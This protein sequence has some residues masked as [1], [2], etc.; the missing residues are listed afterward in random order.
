[1]IILALIFFIILIVVHEYGHF[2]A[3]KRNGVD[4][5]EFGIGFPPKVAGKTMGKGILRSY[6]TI[7]LL[8][9]GGF[10][11]LKGE[12]DEDKVEGGFGRATFWVKTKIILAGVCM[13][14]VVAWLIFTGLALTM[15]IPSLIEDQ[16]TTGSPTTAKNYIAVGLIEPDSPADTAGLQVGD[17]LVAIG[18]Q[19]IKSD[20]GLFETT[21]TFAGQSVIIEYRRN[22]ALST[23]QTTATL[24]TVE[25]EQPFLG[26][27]PAIIEV[28]RYNVID[29]PVAGMGTLLQLSVETYKGLGRLVSDLVGGNFSEAADQVSG[30]VGV[31]VLLDNASV[32]GFEYL[33]F[34]IGVISLTLAIMNSLPIPALDG[35]RLFVTGLFRVLKKPLTKQTESAIHGT[36]FA[37]LMM[38][39]LLISVVDVQRFF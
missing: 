14:F 5:E 33:L 26:V 20:Q 30:P 12:S 17:E 38:L 10:V 8:P 13:N 37:V 18:E 34:F 36:G 32:F 6:Y 11:K 24:N 23:Q 22:G 9:L 3:A 28:N 35:G 29:A 21:E 2:L 7:N 16:Y 4:V 25:S 31:F 27:G 1:M 15:G 19:P 39:I